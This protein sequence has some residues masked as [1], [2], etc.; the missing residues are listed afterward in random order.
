MRRGDPKAGMVAAQAA[1]S[2]IPNSP[3]LTEALGAAQ[4]ASGEFNQAVATFGALV[5][6]QPANPL[7]LLRLAEAQVAVKNYPA[8]I[9]SEQRALALK[10]DLPAALIALTKTY[11]VSGKADAAIAEARRLQKA[12]PDKAMGYALEGELQAVQKKWP[13]AV[14]AFAA[15]ASRE[16]SPLLVTRQYAAL[17][18]AGKAAEGTAIANKWMKEHP[19]DP[20]V[21]LMLAEESQARKDLPTAIAGY[22]KVIALDANN[23]AALN[24]LAWVLTE[25]KDAKGL[26]YAERAQQLAPFNPNILDTYGLALTRNGDAKRGAEM[27]RMA[28]RLAPRQQEIRLHLAQALIAVGDKAGA[29]EAIGELT[30]LDKTSPIRIE[31]EKLQAT[32]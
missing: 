12:H 31:A 7:A 3:Q 16:P 5:K 9:D 27:L 10:P 6:L 20:V 1:V 21:P 2:A 4:L 23:V 30:K 24:N 22:E 15:A 13:E 17:R 32:L 28:S 18:G 11:L 14:S 8:A 25:K 19:T 26:E 29:R